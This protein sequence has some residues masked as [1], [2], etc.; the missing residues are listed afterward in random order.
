MSTIPPSGSYH[1]NTD[2]YARVTAIPESGSL[3]YKWSVDGVDSGSENPIFVKMDT[4]HFISAIFVKDI[5]VDGGGEMVNKT[6]SGK[7]SAVDAGAKI[8][9][10]TVKI[11]ITGGV[12]DNLT[13]VTDTSGNYS[14]TKDYPITATVSA[15]G[16]A[17]VDA[18]AT[19]ASATSPATA[20]QI[21]FALLKRAL[22]FLVS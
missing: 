9:G 4:N 18:D 15:S 7:L 1:Y 21:I 8:S 10:V 13:A 2:T 17:T 14:V 22:T 5:F 6:F 20:F 3:F 16:I 11:A 19:N 12:T